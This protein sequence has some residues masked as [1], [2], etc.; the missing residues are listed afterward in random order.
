MDFT[1]LD[2]REDGFADHIII[3]P[4]A[5]V[6]LPT[7]VSDV[8]ETI[9][10]LSRVEFSESVAEAHIGEIGKRLSLFWCETSHVLIS[11]WVKNINLLMG[12]VE[13]A[14]KDDRLPFLF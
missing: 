5:F 4:P 9:L 13:V 2:T 7:F 14:Y 1:L 3:Q 6:F 11:L 10:N 8:P 12:N